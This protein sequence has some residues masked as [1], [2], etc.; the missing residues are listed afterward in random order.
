MDSMEFN[1][2]A[3]A[4][5]GALLVFLLL[6]FFSTLIYGTEE[7]AEPVLDHDGKPILAY[8]LEIEPAGG[9]QQAAAAPQVDLVALFHNA[10]V[11]KGEKIFGRCG[12]CHS[13]EEGVNKIGPSLHGVIHRN[14]ASLP[15]FSYSDA[16]KSLEGAWTPEE[17][18]HFIKDPRGYAPG[19]KMT[20]AGLK[21]PQE[22]ADVIAYL[23]Q[24]SG[25]PIDLTEGLEPAAA[26]PASQA[27]AEPTA[28]QGSGAA[29]GTSAPAAGQEL[30]AAAGSAPGTQSQAANNVKVTGETIVNTEK[31]RTNVETTPAQ[32][33]TQPNP[34]TSEQAQAANPVQKSLTT[35]EPAGTAVQPGPGT[36]NSTGTSEHAQ[37]AVGTSP[38]QQLSQATQPTAAAGGNGGGGGGIDFST[39]DAK[40][41][42]KIFRRCHACHSIEE[43]ENRVG[44][45]LYNVIDR[46]I[47]SLP[48]YNYSDAMK[49]QKG[50]WTP[51]RLFHYLKD[52]RGVVPGT[53]MTFAGLKDPQDRIDVITYLDQASGNHVPLK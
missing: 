18:F 9:T 19:T 41:G 35:P 1:K 30:A 26:A 33:V 16:L 42:E 22:R 24:A 32:I 50:K 4:S 6:N 49:A 37:T 36:A 43:G 34:M 7:F 52:P 21:D 10:D 40:A 11:A 39:G 3:G 13:I 15:D 47:A 46:N 29:P 25:N 31:E 2:I 23:N 53:K 5:I 17:I 38:A 51:E 14:I 48:D 44:P 27:A 45:S 20:F 8:A 28:A 12:A